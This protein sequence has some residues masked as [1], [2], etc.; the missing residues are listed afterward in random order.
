MEKFRQYL[1]E[2]INSAAHRHGQY[3]QLEDQA[4]TNIAKLGYNAC[5]ASCWDVKTELEHLLHTL[6][7]QA[8][9]QTNG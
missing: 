4:A 7:Q 5:A 2:R 8:K 9:T 3:K 6:D 1:I